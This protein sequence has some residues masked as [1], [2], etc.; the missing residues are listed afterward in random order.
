MGEFVT[1]IELLKTLA[2][3]VPALALFVFVVRLFLSHLRSEGADTREVLRSL[4]NELGHNTQATNT[5]AE[6]L[7]SNNIHD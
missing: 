2:G 4:A 1:D 5:L 3:Q 6:V 7:R